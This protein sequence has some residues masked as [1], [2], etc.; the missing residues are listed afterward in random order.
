MKKEILF[1][2][3]GNQYD[4]IAYCCICYL[5]QTAKISHTLV[6]TGK[7]FHDKIASAFKTDTEVTFVSSLP[8]SLDY[9]DTYEL[10]QLDIQFSTLHNLCRKLGVSEDIEWAATDLASSSAYHLPSVVA[11]MLRR[12]LGLED[13]GNFVAQ[14]WVEHG[15]GW[16]I[17]RDADVLDLIDPM[18]EPDDPVS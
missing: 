1:L 7:G 6:L 10:D 13:F 11:N 15:T 12:R 2:S 5:C 3:D 16:R 4:A 17:T 14:R 9:L 18:E 8:V